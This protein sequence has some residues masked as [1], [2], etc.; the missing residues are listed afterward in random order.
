M[1]YHDDDH[2]S[3]NIISFFQRIKKSVYSTFPLHTHTSNILNETNGNATYIKKE[4]Q[5]KKRVQFIQ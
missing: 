3:H 4:E 1:T 5:R 2:H